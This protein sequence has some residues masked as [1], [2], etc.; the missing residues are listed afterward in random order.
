M[1]ELRATQA[2]QVSPLFVSYS[3]ADS[4]FVDKIGERLTDKGIRYWRDIH[5]LK[6]GRIERQLDQAISQ[7]RTVLLVMSANS[8]RSD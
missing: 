3:H 2:L 4:H 5:D 1:Y 7:N 8:L 6:A